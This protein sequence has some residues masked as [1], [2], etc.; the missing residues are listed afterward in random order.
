LVGPG[1]A[2]ITQQELGTSRAQASAVW[3]C[4]QA[5]KKL[6]K[7]Y[8]RVPIIADGEIKIIDEINQD[9]AK[10]GDIIKALVLG[11][12][13]VMMGSLLAGLDESPGEKEFDYEEN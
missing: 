6:E 1:S 4:A 13:T 12:Q 7:K 11:A 3:D 5:A 10:P 2:C 9:V 8:G